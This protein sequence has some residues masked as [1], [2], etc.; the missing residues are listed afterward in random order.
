MFTAV[1]IDDEPRVRDSLT[2]ML[3]IHCP[4]IKLVGQ[5]NSIETGYHIINHLKPEVVFLD[6]KMPDGTG[7]DLLKRFQKIDFY[8]FIITA[9]EEFAIKAFKFSALDYLLKPIDPSDLIKAVD[10]L[11]S[12]INVEETNRRVNLLMANMEANEM[13]S[14][15]LVL[16]TIDNI[17]IVE[18]KDIVRCESL[19][20]CTKFF[21]V[22]LQ[23]ILV[24]KTLKDYD[25][26]LTPLGFIRCHQSH[27]VNKN[28][29]QSFHR[30]PNPL[31]K[32]K[33]GVIVPVSMRKRG[34][35]SKIKW[36]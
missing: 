22:N 35:L 13:E 24:S 29:V 30:F 17:Y 7:F 31:L 23:E 16:K 33:N 32:L 25:E 4:T 3:A 2:K 26:L 14:N 1:I 8:F 10:K 5:A 18:T 11:T 36:L 9:Y 20:N 12:K 34:E 27:L 28:F 21:T 15:K 6:I 19:N